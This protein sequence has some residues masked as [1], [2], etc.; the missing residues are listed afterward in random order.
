M[1]LYRSV[2]RLVESDR[3]CSMQ[4]PTS[5]IFIIQKSF[6]SK[7]DGAS[8]VG[9][10]VF[11]VKIDTNRSV[12]QLKKE[13]KVENAAKVQCDA[14]DLRLFLAKM[15]GARGAW[16]KSREMGQ[17]VNHTTGL[18]ELDGT[19]R[20]SLSGLS[21][22]DVQLPITDICPIYLLVVLPPRCLGR[23]PKHYAG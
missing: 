2:Y 3:S 21:E 20:L 16:M 22:S 23:K 12:D 17:G 14:S 6:N 10:C 5:H 15:G 19:V 4:I 9:S 7:K 11:C 1:G 18:Q 13:I 8:H